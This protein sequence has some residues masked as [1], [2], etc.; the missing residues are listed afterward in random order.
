MISFKFPHSVTERGKV[1]EDVPFA[2][3]PLGNFKDAWTSFLQEQ[4]AQEDLSTGCLSRNLGIEARFLDNT[5]HAPQPW[6]SFSGE[7]NKHS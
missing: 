5:A 6:K 4:P 3:D 1:D 2:Y 7:N